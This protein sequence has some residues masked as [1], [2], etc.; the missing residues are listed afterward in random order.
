LGPLL[1]V[2]ESIAFF[3]IFEP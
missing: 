3:G 1:K 2:Q